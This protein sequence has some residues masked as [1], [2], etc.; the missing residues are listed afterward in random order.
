[1]NLT[2]LL[3]SSL[4]ESISTVKNNKFVQR[5][6]AIKMIIIQGDWD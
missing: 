4:Y 1:M 6:T 3:P 2:S 5:L